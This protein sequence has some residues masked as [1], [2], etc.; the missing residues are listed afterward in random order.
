MYVPASQYLKPAKY[1]IWIVIDSQ[2]FPLNG[3]SKDLT[4]SLPWPREASQNLWS[5]TGLSPLSASEAIRILY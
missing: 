4:P 3:S 5:K 1:Y 2:V